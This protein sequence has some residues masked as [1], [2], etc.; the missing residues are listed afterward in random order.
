VVLL[1]QH[2][3]KT[4]IHVFHVVLFDQLGDVRRHRKWPRILEGLKA[5]PEL[6]SGAV[7][8][9]SHEEI[10]K[11]KTLCSFT[12][13]AA[14]KC[15][16]HFRHARPPWRSKNAPAFSASR[17]SMAVKKNRRRARHVAGGSRIAGRLAG[18]A[19]VGR[20]ADYMS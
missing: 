7:R 1:A 8:L 3:G 15:I 5:R 14:E 11:R 16:L 12:S 20:K 18:P 19:A 4:Q 17:P 9:S 2:V 10:A 6:G 13:R